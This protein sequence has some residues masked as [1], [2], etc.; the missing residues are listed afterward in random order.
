MKLETAV[1]TDERVK[2][3]V[4]TG[5]G[6]I[7]A[8]AGIHASPKTLS[9]HVLTMGPRLRGDDAAESSPPP[10]THRFQPPDLG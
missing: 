8:N 2:V 7:P 3:L 6:V 1:Y 9:L 4:K 5:R 10:F